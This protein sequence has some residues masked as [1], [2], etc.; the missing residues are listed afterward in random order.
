MEKLFIR[1][2]ILICSLLVNAGI[3]SS[4]QPAQVNNQNND[5]RNDALT[6]AAA[7]NNL[8]TTRIIINNSPR[9]SNR[10]KRNHAEI[11]T[12]S[13]DIPQKCWFFALKHALM[14]KKLSGIM[15]QLS[16]T[17]KS[18]DEEKTSH[19][20]QAARL[21]NPS[22]YKLLLANGFEINKSILN[23][24]TPYLKKSLNA[25]TYNALGIAIIYF[26]HACQ[27]KDENISMLPKQL[28]KHFGAP[29]IEDMCLYRAYKNFPDIFRQIAEETIFL[30]VK[31]EDSAT[32]LVRAAKRFER[33]AAWGFNWREVSYFLVPNTKARKKL[34]FDAPANENQTSEN[35]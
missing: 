9:S 3:Q 1:H 10:K 28:A 17:K 26:D 34:V 33:A 24:I 13:Q 2:T 31:P 4:N 30:N 29:I 6:A 19:V 21:D 15:A 7:Q 35:R 23:Q 27:R 14:E 22:M 32:R 18:A 11:S 8:L 25:A 16:L 20:L 12:C 5:T